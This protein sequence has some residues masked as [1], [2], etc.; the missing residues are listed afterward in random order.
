MM[1]QPV[2]LAA[3]EP[4]SWADRG[5]ITITVTLQGMLTIFLVLASLWAV[6][7]IMHKLLGVRRSDA[8]KA[9]PKATASVDPGKQPQVTVVP[10]ASADDGAVV[11]AITAAISAALAEEGYTGGFRVVSFKRADTARNRRRF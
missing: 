1:F 5:T 3:Q 10:T 7:E 8:G 2:F 4:L 9:S 6:I 11:A